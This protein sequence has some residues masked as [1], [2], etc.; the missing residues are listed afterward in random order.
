MKILPASEAYSRWAETYER[1][2]P[3]TAL[4]C[5]LVDELSR[6]PRGLFLLDVGCGTGRRIVGTGAVQ[7]VGV[8][9]CAEMLAVGRRTHDFGPEV[10]LLQGDA[11]A[12]PL[13]DGYFDL[14]WCR[15]VIGH[16]AD[17]GAAFR[18]LRRVAAAGGQVVVTDF[19]PAAY[20][21]GLRRT[22][23]DGG[24]VLEV[25]HHAHSF[26]D[27]VAAGASAGLRLTASAERSIGPS[28]RGYY[29][30]AEKGDIYAVHRD[31]PVV[32]GLAF[33]RDG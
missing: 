15:L 32:L 9:P 13:P 23:R 17:C 1:E 8:E 27:L 16:L 12:L 6:S 5:R 10:R 20:A 3:V 29:D 18:E 30:R 14:V 11:L 22:F 4:D 24:E 19:H 33:A 21:S 26:E 25:E 31:T 2:N 7:A 28:V